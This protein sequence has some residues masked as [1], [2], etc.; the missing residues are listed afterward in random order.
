M[1][2]NFKHSANIGVNFRSLRKTK[3]M[4]LLF[5]IFVSTREEILTYQNWDM[6]QKD[7][8]LNQQFNLQHK[9]Y[10]SNYN[11]AQYY[12]ISHENRDSGRLYLDIQKKDLRIID[13]AL[14]PHAR[15]L[16]IGTAIISDLLTWAK[17]KNKKVSIHVER[18]NPAKSLY[19]KMGFTE[20]NSDNQVYI[21]METDSF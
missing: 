20:K 13:I 14:L 19:K 6:K 11:S 10:M 5:E 18:D 1:T 15:C 21:L 17:K 7:F 8:F 4:P 2:I 3:D 12:I 16:G 9:A